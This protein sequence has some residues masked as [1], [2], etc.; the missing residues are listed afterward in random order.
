MGLTKGSGGGPGETPAGKV[1]ARSSRRTFPRGSVA[2][3]RLLP[4]RVALNPS[5]SR[6]PRGRP[7]S[8]ESARIVSVGARMAGR[9]LWRGVGL[10][11]CSVSAKTAIWKS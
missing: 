8:H 3:A 10:V 5:P 4:R 2:E 1:T 7:P 11:R 9:R 6:F